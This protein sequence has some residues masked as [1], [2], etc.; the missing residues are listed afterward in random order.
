[1]IHSQSG[2]RVFRLAP[3]SPLVLAF[4]VVAWVIPIALFIEA[5]M[6]PA[7]SKWMLLALVLTGVYGAVWLWWRPTGFELSLTKLEVV[8]PGRRR[9]IPRESVIGARVISRQEFRREFGR[10]MRIGVGGLWGGYGWLWTKRG[11]VDF[12]VS[13]TD[14]FLLIERTSS[15]PLLL[16]PDKPHQMVEA[17][18][19]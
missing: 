4:T 13:R 3:M 15:H 14:G 5:L 8:F 19:S 2:I 17:L 18:S 10:A 11:L 16:T 7:D 1:M 12:Y 9:S 6:N